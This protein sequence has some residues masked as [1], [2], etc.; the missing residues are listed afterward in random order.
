MSTEDN[1]DK[2]THNKDGA[3]TKPTASDSYYQY[4]TLLSLALGSLFIFVFNRFR[5]KNWIPDSTIIVLCGLLLG[6][7]LGSPNEKDLGEDLFTTLFFDF[8]MPAIAFAAGLNESRTSFTGILYAI[9]SA[10]LSTFLIGQFVEEYFIDG[11]DKPKCLVKGCMVWGVV[12]APVNANFVLTSTEEISRHYRESD[13]TIEEEEELESKIEHPLLPLHKTLDSW[14]RCEALISGPIAVVFFTSLRQDRLRGLDLDPEQTMLNFARVLA[15]SLLLGSLLGVLCALTLRKP[16]ETS[17]R[18][19]PYREVSLIILWAFASFF[20]ARFLSLSAVGTLFCAGLML[21]NTALRMVSQEARHTTKI[22][23]DA[24]AGLSESVVLLY[25]GIASVGLI[26]SM[27]YGGN[28][29]LLT[30]AAVLLVCVASRAIMAF[31]VS[32]VLGGGGYRRFAFIVT[33]LSGMRGAVSFSLALKAGFD[34]KDLLAT[35]VLVAL[36]S[37]VFMSPCL[38]LYVDASRIK[39][40]EV[41]PLAQV[42]ASRGANYETITRHTNGV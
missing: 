33:L 20:L 4:I 2:I 3:A 21:K 12:M 14:L 30:P 5:S 13:L 19:G 38:A 35:S 40:P 17:H 39:R 27:R 11:L 36:F 9:M 28:G 34:H 18:G 10:I 7:L 32:I 26:Q 1:F 25:M 41:H 42:Y 31:G 24:I 22:G 15:G 6:L 16:S 8:C 23:S 37:H 29:E